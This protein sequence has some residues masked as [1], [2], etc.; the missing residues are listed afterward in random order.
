MLVPRER[1]ENK[2][3]EVGFQF[4]GERRGL[5]IFERGDDRIQLNADDGFLAPTAAT[6]HLRRGAGCNEQEIESFLHSVKS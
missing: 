1:L 4:K 2:L 6:Y 5:R 3:L